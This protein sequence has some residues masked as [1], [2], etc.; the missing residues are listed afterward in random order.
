MNHIIY[1]FQFC[2]TFF[3]VLSELVQSL[4]FWL[5]RLPFSWKTPLGYVIALTV[6]TMSIYSIGCIAVP[7]QSFLIGSC[8]LLKTFVADVAHHLH[9]INLSSR[10][11]NYK[12]VKKRVCGILRD[13]SEMK[14][15]SVIQR[16]RYKSLKWHWR[17]MCFCL[18]LAWSTCWTIFLNFVLLRHSCG[19]CW[20]FGILSLYFIF[21]KLSAKMKIRTH[22]PTLLISTK[23][24]SFI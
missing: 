12:N 17:I 4:L 19:H 10:R 18:L 13:L 3:L 1:R 16:R 23:P 7:I 15:L 14:Q 11:K 21:N 9:K 5:R 24:D 20:L 8:W 22:R 2:K 6:E